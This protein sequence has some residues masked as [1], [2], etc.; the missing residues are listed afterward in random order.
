MGKYTRLLRLDPVEL[1]GLNSGTLIERFFPEDRS[2][3]E[4]LDLDKSLEGIFFLL[5]R[6][7]YTPSVNSRYNILFDGK[8]FIPAIGGP[9]DLVFIEILPDEVKKLDD[10]LVKVEL[11]SIRNN[12]D[13]L[14]MI[15]NYVYPDIWEYGNESYDYLLTHFIGMKEFIA[16]AAL[17]SQVILLL[18]T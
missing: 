18:T 5:T 13:P 1:K 10:L 3:S 7:A 8:P 9:V 12:Y 17:E 6:S 16:S 11:T 4:F 14:K 2:V 15:A